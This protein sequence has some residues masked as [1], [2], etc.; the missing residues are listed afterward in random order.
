MTTIHLIK[1]LI[2]I[3]LTITCVWWV[4]VEQNFWSISMLVLNISSL[5]LRGVLIGVDIQK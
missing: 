1:L 4:A 5:F 3:L 2:N